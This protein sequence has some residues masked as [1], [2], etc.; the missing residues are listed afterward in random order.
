[1]VLEMNGYEVNAYTDPLEV[2]SDFKP[3]SY[4]LALL[5]IRMEPIND[6][7][8]YKKMKNIDGSLK[9]CFITASFYFVRYSLPKRLQ[10]SYV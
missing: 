4:G 7:E 6:F 10:I 2:L 5:D 8:L 9:T 1:M 3:D